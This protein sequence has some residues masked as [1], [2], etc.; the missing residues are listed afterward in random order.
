MK[1]GKKPVEKKWIVVHKTS[2]TGDPH[3]HTHLFIVKQ[4]S[5]EKK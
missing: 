1:N 5:D 4:E 3:T 2:A